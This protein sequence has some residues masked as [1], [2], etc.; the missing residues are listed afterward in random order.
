MRSIINISLPSQLEEVVNREVIKGSYASKSEFFRYLLRSYIESS[1]FK[2]LE[3]SRKELSRD[4]G[5]LLTSLK[6]LR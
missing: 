2:E 3:K 6:D 5:K 4:K 1:F